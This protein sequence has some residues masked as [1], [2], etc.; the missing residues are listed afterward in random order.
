V[1]V[2]D[3]RP[4]PWPVHAAILSVLLIAY[5]VLACLAWPPSHARPSHGGLEQGLS[6]LVAIG[7]G[8][9]MAAILMGGACV[10]MYAAVSTAVLGVAPRH[11]W[12][13]HGILMAL[14]AVAALVMSR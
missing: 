5:G 8:A 11:P 2:E 13:V 14:A 10:L 12:A 3:L 9:A 6:V 1:A 7:E 4:S